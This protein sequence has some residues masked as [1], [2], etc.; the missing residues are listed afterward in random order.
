MGT[1]Y[2]YVGDYLTGEVCSAVVCNDDEIIANT[3]EGFW[4]V[5]GCDHVIWEIYNTAQSM[6]VREIQFNNRL[7]R[8]YH[9][10]TEYAA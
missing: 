9:E 6:D 2:L 10:Y 7:A 8:A 3:Y 1:V 5:L 4:K